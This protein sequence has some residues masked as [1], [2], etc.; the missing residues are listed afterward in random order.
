VLS[1]QIELDALHFGPSRE[2]KRLELELKE[3]IP[4]GTINNEEEDEAENI[5][6]F[7]RKAAKKL[8]TLDDQSSNT[9]ALVP[10][11]QTL[12]N[13]EEPGSKSQSHRN[14]SARHQCSEEPGQIGEQRVM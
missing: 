2:N 9:G 6:N 3:V 12:P 14:Q 1:E 13:G 8:D 4:C 11:L 5:Y 7:I 10:K